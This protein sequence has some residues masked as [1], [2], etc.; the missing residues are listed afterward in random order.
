[1]RAHLN[2]F[3]SFEKMSPKKIQSFQNDRNKGLIKI[4][5]KK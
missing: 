4:E 5:K 2:P 1:M 3:N